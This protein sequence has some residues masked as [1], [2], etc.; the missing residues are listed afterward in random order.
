MKKSDSLIYTLSG[1]MVLL[2]F[3]YY[4]IILVLGS[5]LAINVAVSL[6]DELSQKQILINTFLSS[7]AVSGMFCSM[8]YIKRLY[9]ACL[10][11]RIILTQDSIETLGNLAYFILRPFYAFAFVII[12]IFGL[13]SGMFVVTG[14][15]D[16]ILNVKFVYLCV[17]VSGGF[18][19]SIGKIM[20]KF[21]EISEERIQKID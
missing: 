9:K 8:Q 7:L 11:E 21:E 1:K 18:G 3:I 14:S 12:M 16:Y 13:L 20:D 10:T 19:Y 17:I 4:F 15:L 2:L 6:M 5:F